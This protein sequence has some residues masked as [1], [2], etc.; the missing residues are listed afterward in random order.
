MIWNAFVFMQPDMTVTVNNWLPKVER[1][2][3]L[4]TAD[5]Q[6]NFPWPVLLDFTATH[7]SSTTLEDLHLQVRYALFKKSMRA[8]YCCNPP[9]ARSKIHCLVLTSHSQTS[10]LV[11][12]KN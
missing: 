9:S 10:F 11:C 1:S 12:E 7:V 8:L 5:R 2:R 4:R 3:I 6:L